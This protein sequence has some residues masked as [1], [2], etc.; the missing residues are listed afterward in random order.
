[1]HSFM[2]RPLSRI[3]LRPVPAAFPR[4]REWPGARLSA[5]PAGAHDDSH[6]RDPRVASG[7]REVRSLGAS[8]WDPSA[9]LLRRGISG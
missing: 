1:M 7:A 4:V 9:A 2:R 6:G 8:A 5:A 3:D